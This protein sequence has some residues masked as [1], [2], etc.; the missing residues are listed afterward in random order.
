[1]TNAQSLVNKFDEAEITFNQHEVS[2]G[3]ITESWF[4]PNIPDNQL[5]INGYNVFSKCRDRKRGDSVA[6]YTKEGIPAS[7]TDID[8]PEQLECLWIK[9]RPSKLPREISSI[10]IC[11][12]YITTDSPFQQLLKNH[13]LHSVDYLKTRYPD[14]GIV[15]LGD[16]NR[17]N[18]SPIV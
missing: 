16:F 13:L 14:I 4:S 11:V 12:V 1:M 3:V 5:N 9:V 2:I 18:S 6:V 17:R 10:V 15:I 8:V 7:K